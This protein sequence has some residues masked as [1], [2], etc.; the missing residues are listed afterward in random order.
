MVTKVSGLEGVDRIKDGT[1]QLED[2]SLS[3]AAAVIPTL[4][5]YAELEAYAGAAT[6]VYV[7]GRLSD[8]DGAD[9][10][11]AVDEADTTSADNDGTIL[12]DAGGRRWKRQDLSSPSPKWWGADGKGVVDSTSAFTKFELV[13]KNMTVNLSGTYLVTPTPTGN[14]YVNGTFIDSGAVVEPIDVNRQMTPCFH[15]NGGQLKDLRDSLCNPFEQYINIVFVGD[16]ITWGATLPENAATDPRQGTLKDRR[17]DYTAPSFVNLFKRYVGEVYASGDDPELSNWSFSDGGTS[18]ATFKKS[19]LMYPKY[20]PFTTINTGLA[21]S[22]EAKSTSS[23]LGYQYRLNAFGTSAESSI[24]F[25][26]TGNSFDF[27]YTSLAGGSAKY[28]VFVGSVSQGVFHTDLGVTSY[29][30][31]RT[32]AFPYAIGAEIK[33]KVYV[34]PSDTVTQVLRIEAIDLVKTINI[35]NQAIIGTT[36]AQYAERCFGQYGPSLLS[37]P[38]SYVI[39]QLGTN[40]RHKVWP[41]YNKANGVGNFLVNMNSLLDLFPVNVKV[42]LMN[43]LPAIDEDP[44][45]KSM[46]MSDVK[47]IVSFV[48]KQRSLDVIDNYTIFKGMSDVGYNADGLHPNRYGHN[49]IFNN[50]VN[51]I[52]VS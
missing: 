22:D 29:K 48:G 15:R 31:K 17:D 32:H 34:S 50:I 35:S 19:Y 2:F 45:T 40:D 39:M 14:R 41:N 38:V 8:Q 46:S 18:D 20:S 23:A 33:I 9:G 11:F 16:S 49:R 1:I 42:I 44:T 24:N 51:S 4:K 28:E 25:S 12:I 36:S 47:S 37:V 43:S 27:V 21:T 7:A 26:M 5:T 3:A 6:L 13:F 30:N 52:E 10:M